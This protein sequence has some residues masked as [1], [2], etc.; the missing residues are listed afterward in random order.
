MDFGGKLWGF[1]DV[2]LVQR[3]VGGGAGILRDFDRE[4]SGDVLWGDG[5]RGSHAL[6][7]LSDLALGDRVWEEHK[8]IDQGFVRQLDHRCLRPLRSCP[9][10][11]CPLRRRPL[12]DRDDLWRPF[13]CWRNWQWR[14]FPFWV[15]ADFFN[16]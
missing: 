8:V 14:S 10:R 3:E 11:R 6:G 15:S 12:L 2:P 5:W 4:V 16:T 9:L 1:E 13:H 7:R